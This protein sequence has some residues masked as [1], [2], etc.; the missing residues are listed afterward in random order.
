MPKIT[1]NDAQSAKS[2]SVGEAVDK[3]ERQRLKR[4]KSKTESCIRTD[5]IRLCP[6]RGQESRPSQALRLIPSRLRP[7]AALGLV[8]L[9]L[10]LQAD[11]R[12]PLGGQLD[13]TP[14]RRTRGQGDSRIPRR[15][16][17]SR[18]L[19]ARRRMEEAKARQTR[20]GLQRLPVEPRR[21]PEDLPRA[22][23]DQPGQGLAGER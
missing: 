2:E 21:D 14:S 15:L 4:K 6:K 7:D 13:H 3:I 19:G 12:Q 22:L 23:R 11:R 1:S 5:L 20:R 16:A 10:R 18:R 17:G 8:R 9:D